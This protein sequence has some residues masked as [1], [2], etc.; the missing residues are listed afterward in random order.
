MGKTY[1]IVHSVSFDYVRNVV[2]FIHRALRNAL[3]HSAELLI[4]DEI[5]AADHEDGALIF[6][7]G[8]NFSRHIRRSGC[9]YIYLNF[10]VVLALGNPLNISRSGWRAIRRKN[11]MLHEKLDLFDVLLDYYPQQTRVLQKRLRL[12]VLHFPVAVDPADIPA[13]T[14]LDLRKYD[15]CF[16]GG[17]TERRS[18]IITA[19][20]AGGLRLSPH[21]GV[22]F[23]D[24]V[25]QSRC[26]LNVHSQKSNHLETPRI[27]GALAAAT[28]TVSER[29]YGLRD[30]ISEDLLVTSSISNIARATIELCEDQAR[31]TTLSARSHVWYRQTYLPRCYSQWHTLVAQLSKLLKVGIHGPVDSD[32]SAH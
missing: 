13:T 12:P 29:S 18:K 26:C 14:P 17:L 27:V 24:A 16:V 19:L 11:S 15:V 2:R 21:E 9:W 23:E 20:S 7:I 5:D 4:V 1:L 8:E 22:V 30:L 28:P 6:V 31:L 32:L 10:S 25:A 3:D